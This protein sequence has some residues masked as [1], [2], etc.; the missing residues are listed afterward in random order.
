LKANLTIS[1]LKKAIQGKRLTIKNE[2]TVLFWHRLNYQLISIEQKGTKTF[3][4]VDDEY[5]DTKTNAELILLNLLIYEYQDYL[6]A[7]DYLIWCKEKGLS[8][9]STEARAHYS[10]LREKEHFLSEFLEDL[11]PVSP[12]EWQLNS[13][14]AQAL[15]ENNY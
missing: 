12:L 6:E 4:L 14:E 7:S 11:T 2:P 13:G 5:G 1:K 15:R 10:N 8:V 9:E 3:I